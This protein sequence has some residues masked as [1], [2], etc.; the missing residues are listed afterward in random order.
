[1]EGLIFSDSKTKPH[2]SPLQTHRKTPISRTNISSLRIE[3]NVCPASRTIHDSNPSAR[4][5]PHHETLQPHRIF[6]VS[7]LRLQERYVSQ[8]QTIPREKSIED[9]HKEHPV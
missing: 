2:P 1:M 6:P 7:A 4:P 5:C 9:P 3:S 8:P